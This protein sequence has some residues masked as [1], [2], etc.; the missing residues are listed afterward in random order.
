MHVADQAASQVRAEISRAGAYQKQ[1]DIARC[2]SG[3]LQ[4]VVDGTAT[5]VHGPAQVPQVQFV[6]GLPTIPVLRVQVEM[7]EVDTAIQKDFANLRVV[8]S[9]QPERF[10]L[11]KAK[12]RICLADGP[13]PGIV[14]LF[15]LPVKLDLPTS[16]GII[17]LGGEMKTSFTPRVSLR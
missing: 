10:L 17:A 14:H 7:A 8:I 13:D 1:I 2:H 11:R 16:S 12:W 15:S 6:R 3:L 4:A 5:R 9:S